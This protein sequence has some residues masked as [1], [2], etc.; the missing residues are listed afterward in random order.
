MSDDTRP[1]EMSA[2]AL[3]VGMLIG[4]GTGF[5]LWMV[6]STFVFF[7]AFLGVGVAIGVAIQTARRNDD[8]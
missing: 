1:G 3:T 5:V 6:T 4:A 2:S 8:Q 7:P